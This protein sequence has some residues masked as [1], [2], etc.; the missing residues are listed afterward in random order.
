MKR[1]YP[2]MQ[3]ILPCAVF[4]AVML[5]AI[6]SLAGNHED[7]WSFMIQPYIWFPTID[8]ELRYTAL[9]NGSS[10]SPEIKVYPD[11]WLENLDLAVLLTAGVRKGEWSFVADFTYLDLSSSE[12]AVKN[13]NFG[14]DLVSTSLDAGTEVGMKGF[15]TTFAGGYRV[16]DGQIL[17]TDLVAGA[18]YLWLEAD[19]DWK[20]SADVAGPGGGQTFD[21]RGNITEDEDVWNGIVG[22]RGQIMLGK[23]HWFIPYYADIG[24][25]DCELTWQVFS[26]LAYAFNSWDIA[27]GY[28]HLEFDADDDDAFIQKLSFTGPVVGAVFRF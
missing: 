21:R 22:V 28:R 14:G 2:K 6:T 7:R 9:P 11:D 23:S 1:Y 27:V 24:A 8:S 16:I 25:G 10:G 18:R 17:K 20:L 15:V 19:T 5:I 26:A 3:K 13:I 12:S 4:I